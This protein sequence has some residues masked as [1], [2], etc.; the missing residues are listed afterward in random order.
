MHKP[1]W[2]AVVISLEYA[3]QFEAEPDSKSTLAALLQFVMANRAYPFSVNQTLEALRL[4]RAHPEQDLS[5][6]L[7]QRHSD[8]TLRRTFNALGDILAAMPTA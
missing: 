1:S 2:Q 7:P 8:S 3:I 4:V 6:L 5:K